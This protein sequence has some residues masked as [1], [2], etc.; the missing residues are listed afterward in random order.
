MRVFVITFLVFLCGCYECKDNEPNGIVDSGEKPTLE[1]E[2]LETVFYGKNVTV[3]YE[4]KPLNFPKGCRYEVIQESA[5]GTK[6]VMDEVFKNEP[7]ERVRHVFYLN[8]FSKGESATW[9]FRA[10][11]KSFETKISVVPFPFKAKW[12]DGA[13]IEVLVVTPELFHI[14]GKGI[15]P[16]EVL[17]VRS[18]SK[19]EVIE[20]LFP[21]LDHGVFCDFLSPSVIGKK[22]GICHYSVTRID[23]TVTLHIPWGNMFRKVNP[24]ECLEEYKDAI[25]IEQSLYLGKK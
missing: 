1:Q 25:P 23:E 2:R 19:G 4:I 9:T 13:E 7:K 8:N 24:D 16:N 12:S 3:V 11:N 17:K 22:G 21:T 5:D 10:K 14:E 20:G 15:K 6:Y 18:D